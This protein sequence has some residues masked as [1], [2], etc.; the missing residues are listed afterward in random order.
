[1]TA[2]TTEAFRQHV[3]QTPARAA[4]V[5]ARLRQ[6]SV[7]PEGVPADPLALP[8]GAA[9]ERAWHDRQQALRRQLKALLAGNKLHAGLVTAALSRPAAAG[10][11]ETPDGA[12]N[13]GVT[14]YVARAGRWIE[15]VTDALARRWGADPQALEATEGATL[16]GYHRYALA[17]TLVAALQHRPDAPDRVTP[18]Q[19]AD[20][21]AA[22]APALPPEPTVPFVSAGPETDRALAWSRA[23]TRVA[24]AAVEAPFNRPLDTVLADARA[25][26]TEAVAGRVAALT[27]ALPVPAEARPIVEQHALQTS[28]RLY[29]ATLRHVHQQS[30]RLIERYQALQHRGRV[31]EADALARDYQDQG[32]GYAGVPHH[33]QQMMALHAAQQAAAVAAMAAWDE[34]ETPASRPSS[35]EAAR[36]AETPAR[37]PAP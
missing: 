1:M 2:L 5:L 12:P 3:Q 7:R 19:M 28:A 14:D 6:Q 37:P 4:A 26:L 21:L 11:P 13:D 9:G 33:F 29:A 20:D 25:V 18:E 23:L 24:E 31:D 15:A 8:G 22:P 17:R 16:T 27:I 30:A 36:R 32:L 35:G 34:T 10:A